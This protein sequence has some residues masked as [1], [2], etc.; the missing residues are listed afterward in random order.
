MSTIFEQYQIMRI[1]TYGSCILVFVKQVL[2]EMY[3]AGVAMMR[4]FR[5][6]VCNQLIDIGHVIAY[7][8]HFRLSSIEHFIIQLWKT[9]LEMNL[10]IIVKYWLMLAIVIPYSSW[11][12]FG[13]LWH[14]VDQSEDPRSFPTISRS[15]H[16]CS[17]RMTQR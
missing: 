16:Y 7:H 5:K 11:H 6:N 2:C 15:S 8:Y 1:Q 9:I 3:Y 12:W 17:E 13:L 14:I 10:W 4:I